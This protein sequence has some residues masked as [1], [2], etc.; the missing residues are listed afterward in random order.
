MAIG[1]ILWSFWYIF[2]PFW[3]AAPRQIWHPCYRQVFLLTI[4]QVS[5]KIAAETIF[6]KFKNSDRDILSAQSLGAKK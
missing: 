3:Y 5:F 6:K 4:S 1:Y 2:P